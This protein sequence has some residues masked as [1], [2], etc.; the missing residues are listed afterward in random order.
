MLYPTKEHG[1]LK[2]RGCFG[3][4]SLQEVLKFCSSYRGKR[5]S[6]SLAH[7]TRAGDLHPSDM[8]GSSFRVMDL[9]PLACSLGPVALAAQVY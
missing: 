5:A 8:S 6:K 2:A 9:I 1:L 3:A 4:L 7:T